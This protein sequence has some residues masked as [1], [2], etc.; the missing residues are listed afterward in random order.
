[1][2]DL[3]DACESRRSEL[4]ASGQVGFMACAACNAR[5]V[6]EDSDGRY[7][8][9]HDVT[10]GA[11]CGEDHACLVANR[12]ERPFAPPEAYPLVWTHWAACPVSGDP[13]LVLQTQPLLADGEP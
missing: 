6:S 8:L 2:T 9:I 5:Q 13:I 11:R 4:S 7:L 12:F 10:N 3:C 1:M